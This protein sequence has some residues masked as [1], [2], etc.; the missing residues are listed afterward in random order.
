[1]TTRD[2]RFVASRSRRHPV[3][4]LH[5]GQCREAGWEARGWS[6]E[7]IDVVHLATAVRRATR[8]A[9]MLGLTL[10]TT[11]VCLVGRVPGAEARAAAIRQDQLELIAAAEADGTI[12]AEDAATLRAK[13]SPPA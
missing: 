4:F 5:V 6:Q 10:D 13:V 9:Q 8:L 12:S 1:M 2:P 3:L 7:P 11:C